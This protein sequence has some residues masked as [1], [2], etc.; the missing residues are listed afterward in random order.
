MLILTRDSLYDFSKVI[1]NYIPKDML[2]VD[3]VL[4]NIG[5]G[6]AISFTFSDMY[7][8]TKDRH[9]LSFHIDITIIPSVSVFPKTIIK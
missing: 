6:E 2:Y 8:I 9:K 7:F 4:S 3:I 5:R 1:F